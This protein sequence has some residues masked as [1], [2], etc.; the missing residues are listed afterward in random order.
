MSFQNSPEH[1]QHPHAKASTVHDNAVNMT[2]NE[3]KNAR[4]LIEPLSYSRSTLYAPLAAPEIDQIM[5]EH[6]AEVDT[7]LMEIN[8]LQNLLV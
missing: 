7:L 2:Y 8:R 6:R 3:Q 4:S 5:A 1:S